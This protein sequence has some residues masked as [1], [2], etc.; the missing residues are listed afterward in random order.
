MTYETWGVFVATGDQLLMALSALANSHRLRILACLTTKGRT[1]ISQLA[2]DV[3]ISR[4]LLHLHLQKLEDA[5][6]VTGKLEL[7]SDGKALN[8]FEVTDFNITL[9]PSSIADAVKSLTTSPPKADADTLS[10]KGNQHD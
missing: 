6:L 3:G 2:R 1:Y 8:F 7:S 9:N 5:G 10:Q 4:P